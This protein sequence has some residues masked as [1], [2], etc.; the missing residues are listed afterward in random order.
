[1]GEGPEIVFHSGAMPGY[2]SW[3][4][5]DPKRR[6]GVVLLQN[7]AFAANDIAY[8]LLD[9]AAPLAQAAEPR[10]EISLPA[11]QLAKYVGL[12]AWDGLPNA[13]KF[14]VTVENGHLTTQSGIKP[15]EAV[16]PETEVM[17]F[18]KSSDARIV[19]TTDT[20][21]V[22]TGLVL[23]RGGKDETAKKVE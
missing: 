22:P 23:R 19:F 2:G 21:G 20:A 11:E 3:L 6:I 8:H 17:F 4:G 10:T 14:R 18:F 9:P 16:F 15:K 1:M 5:F 12:Y 13:D 7:T